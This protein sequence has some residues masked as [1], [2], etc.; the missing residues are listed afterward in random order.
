M[1]SPGWVAVNYPALYRNNL[2]C[3]ATA[4]LSYRMTECNDYTGG[5]NGASN[6]FVSALWALDY[7]YWWAA[8]GCVGVNFH[9]KRWLYTDTIYLD[10]AGNLRIN[11][12]AYGL[13]AFELGSHGCI[14]TSVKQANPNRLNLDG[15]AVGNSTNL[16][17]TI[18]NKTHDCAGRDAIVT[19]KPKHFAVTNAG[20]VVLESVPSGDCQVRDAMLGG[21]TI[22]STAL[23]HGNWVPLNVSKT[24]RRELTVKPA[25]AAVVHIY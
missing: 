18:I 23:W 20:Y 10:S 14:I 1:L 25:S 11:P 7:M 5:V 4:G 19:I 13:K 17:V 2:T 15:Y 16:Y 21:S 12:K 8:H 6:A 24:G 9:N 22:T 3:V